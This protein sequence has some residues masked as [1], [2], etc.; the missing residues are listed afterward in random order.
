VIRTRAYAVADA[1]VA[2][3]ALL[4]VC[5]VLYGI[6]W[7]ADFGLSPEASPLA[8]LKAPGAVATLTSLSEVTVGVLGIAITVVAIIVELAANRYTPRITELFLRD[9]IN[10]AAMSFFV[11]TTVMMIWIDMSLFGPVHPGNMAVAGAGLMTVSLLAILPYFAYVFDFLSPT[12]VIQRIQ[13]TG[14]TSVE[15]LARGQT[16]VTEARAE[17]V[18]AVEQLGDIALNSVDK[19]DKPLT[20]ACLNALGDLARSSLRCKSELPDA[21]FDSSVLVRHDQDFIALHPDM[22]RSLTSRRTWA[23]MKILRQF[24]AVFSESVNRMRDVNHLIAILTR[25]VAR[26]ALERDDQDAVQLAIRFMNTYMRSALNGKDVRSAYN[27]LNEYRLLA[28]TALRLG[29][30]EVVLELANKMAFYGQLAFAQKLAF[31]LESVAYDLCTLIETASMLES[32]CHD[33]LL[34]VFL[35]VDREPEGG[36]AQ[37]ESLR[38]VRKAQIKLA[39]HY[40]SRRQIQPA[41][42]IF[43]D[44]RKENPVRLESIRNELEAVVEAEYWEV[45]D[46]GIN[47]EFLPPE[48]R[49]Q[50]PAFYAWFE[51]EATD[52]SRDGHVG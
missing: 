34:I 45:S 36:K 19:K 38:G 47:F 49:E 21:W 20:F 6:L 23:E 11:V 15:R 16:D 22:V 10:A 2:F 44:M 4:S 30:H 18:R 43:E 29:H 50:L 13:L 28:E 51:D 42:T 52:R 26:F 40:L 5:I 35:D 17:V 1:A 7:L 3:A 41:R 31:V 32:S 46:R 24:Q 12:R 33:D 37:E 25:Q 14:S 39:T 9:P 27:L 8:L 48:R